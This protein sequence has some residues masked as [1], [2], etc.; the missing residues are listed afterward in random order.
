MA[1]PI[2]DFPTPYDVQLTH[3]PAVHASSMAIVPSQRQPGY[4]PGAY[5]HLLK[6]GVYMI[7]LTYDGTQATNL[8]HVDGDVQ[9]SGDTI[10][11]GGT[12]GVQRTTPYRRISVTSDDEFLNVVSNPSSA[13]GTARATISVIPFET[14]KPA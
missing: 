10:P 8:R 2:D 11:G 7:S 4:G 12:A 13:G 3:D 5:Q 9:R 6:P 1:T 14:Y